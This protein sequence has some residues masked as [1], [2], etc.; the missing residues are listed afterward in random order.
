MNKATR[1]ITHLLACAT[2]ATL[3]GCGGG[4]ETK[5]DPTVVNPVAPVSDWQLVWSDEFDGSAIDDNNWTHEVN[6]AGGGNNEKQCYT[7]SAANSYVEDG[8]LHIVALPAE[9][10]AEKP[11]T[12]A[13]MVTKNKADFKYGRFEVRA[14]LPSG[15]GSWPAFWMLPTDEV[16]GGWP[17]SGEID[18]LEAVNL[19]T[20]DAE[21]LEETRIY[22]TLHY[23]R[24]WPNNV[25]SGREYQLP[26]GASPADDFHTYAIEWQEG[27][28][29]WYVDDYLYATQ[30]KS[31]VRTNSKGE[32]VGLSHR[33]WFAEYFDQITGELTT[34]WNNAPFDQD[35][36]MILNLAVGG[37]WPENVNNLGIDAAAFADGQHF[38]IDYVR[39]YECI[40]NPDTG[41]GC[42]TV[43]GGYDSYDDALVEG[44]APIPSPPS[45]GGPAANLTIF[46]GTINPNW[47]AWDCCGGSTPTVVTDEELGDVMEFYVGASPTVNG[48][49]SRDEFITD[50]AGSASPY[51]ASSLVD[52]GGTVSFDLKVVNPP[53]NPDS[54]WLIKIESV[55]A[56]TAVE[57]PLTNSVEGV[58]P[59]SGQ[60]QSYTF[61][62]S[63]LADA[64]LDLSAIDVIMVFPAWGTGEGATYRLA[65]VEIAADSSGPSLVLFEDAENAKWPMWDCCGGS[66]PEVVVDE[67][68]TYGATAQF[69]IGA[70]PTVMGFISKEAFLPEGVAPAPFD[71][72]SILSNG[73][74]QFDMKIVTL[75][76][77]ASATWLFKI[78]GDDA[79]TAVELPLSSSV[80][81]AMP[82][83]GQW[84][85]YTFKLS[86]LA[87][88]GLDVSAIDVV[89]VFPAWGA[90]EGAVYRI[91]NAKI[92]DP[93]ASGGFVGDVLFADAPLDGWDIW[94]CCGGSTPTLENDDAA[95][96]MTAEFVIGASPTV[97]GII[98]DRENAVSLD[99]SSL[100]ANGVVQFELKVVNAP[101]DASAP[102]L[103]KIESDN[104]ATAVELPLTDSQEGVAPTVGEW[105]TYTYSLQSLFDAGLDLS[106]I[107]VLMVFPAWGSGEG[108]VYHLDNIMIFDP[109]SVPQA[110]GLVLYDNAQNS[111]WPIWDCCAGSTPTEQEDDAA[112][113][114]VAEFVIGATPTVMGF[115][116]GDGIYYDASA[117]LDNGV[118]RFDLKVVT[119]PN[120]PN[121]QWL[122]KIESNDA[123]EA[124]ELPLTDSLEGVTPTVGEWQTYTFRLSDL[125]DAGLDISA[126]DVVMVFPAWGTGEGAVYRIDN[127][128]ITAQQL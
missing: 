10:G 36:H 91:D 104:G 125:F 23:G 78:E 106:A 121:S 38:E 5:T 43:R 105:Q 77:D 29:R 75:P 120:D 2:T 111:D 94:D 54:T 89:M 17:K 4:A 126:I 20:V 66:T 26:D 19:K 1:Q 48:F 127:A 42:E 84:Q 51:D 73:V 40:Q 124:V 115:L 108:A 69:S 62:L 39:V 15:Q 37:D 96:G 46:S 74:V 80:E 128:M 50:P 56:S 32:A 57:W 24:D 7:D 81:G 107:D 110:T 22:G 85:T 118:V 92:Y 28:I 68:A 61:N 95:H 58:E 31:T 45:T 65:N 12:S 79:A 114:M 59:V 14:K 71:A 13:R 98:A 21:G 88:A 18:I 76:N 100:L 122:F 83:A 82:V 119:A 8:V 6:C 49:I 60:W 67:D 97:M 87:N 90:G 113:G 72:T 116:A 52:L 3:V 64:G 103:F 27:E 47:P 16:Y 25:N 101:N 41:K 44:A 63:D 102:W 35:F 99:A 86:D 117:M 93:N 112:H 34:Y 123:G 55:G 70:N 9:D 53:N 33:G 109:S 30:R 11:F